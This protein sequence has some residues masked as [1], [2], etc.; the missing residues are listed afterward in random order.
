V[1]DELQSQLNH[2]PLGRKLWREIAKGQ[3]HAGR[4]PKDDVAYKVFCTFSFSIT[5]A[6]KAGTCRLQK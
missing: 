2:L 3:K 4:L 5:D 6:I 1:E